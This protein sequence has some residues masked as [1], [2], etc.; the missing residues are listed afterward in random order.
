MPDDPKDRPLRVGL[1]G[2]GLGGA[3]FHAPLIAVT[4]GLRLTTIATRDTERQAQARQAHPGV[5]LV[6][7]AEALL[8]RADALDVVVV[9]APNGAHAP[10]ARAALEAGLH[11]VVDKPFATTAADAR[12]LRDLAAARGRM[13]VPYHNRRWDGDFLTVR[14]LLASGALGD[15]H[16]FES[17][18]E[19]WRPQP[20]PRWTASSARAD[21]EGIVLDLGTHLVDQALVLFGR[22]R[23]V[24]AE[25]ARRR[26]D[27][28]VA[29]DLFVSLTHASGVQSHLHATMSAGQSVLRFA[30]RGARAAYVK[31]GTDVQ[32]AALR[33]GGRPDRPGWGE[34][35]PHDWGTLAAGGA[36]QVVRTLPGGYQHFYAGVVAALRDGAP[37]P[38]EA[39]D[40]IAGLEILEAAE[41]SAALRE[42]VSLR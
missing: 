9:A 41:R 38:V 13:I 14:Q 33:E 39:D 15:V 37:P 16:R 27:V 21:G 28:A 35:P 19:R 2:Y 11:V 24:Y 34:E 32:E 23:T 17:R 12:A 3:V 1:I 42:V 6:A 8:A 22:V 4:P 10:I 20:K 26:G 36:R 31:L 40:A 18:F 7:D 30:V 29:D 25:L 5:Q